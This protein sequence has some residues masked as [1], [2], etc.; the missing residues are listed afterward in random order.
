MEKLIIANLKLKRKGHLKLE[1]YNLCLGIFKI[2]T[3]GI[4]KQSCY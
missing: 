3:I 4:L 2:K 1:Y